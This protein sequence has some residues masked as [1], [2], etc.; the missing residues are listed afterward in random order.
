MQL[1]MAMGLRYE[2]GAG[3]S[4]LTDFSRGQQSA[5]ARPENGLPESVGPVIDV[6]AIE[7]PQ[8]QPVKAGMIRHFDYL[9][10]DLHADTVPLPLI[11]SR[12]D[13][14]I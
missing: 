10:Y 14:V 9:V 11:G 4:L 7:V 3:V 12:L 5:A 2:P 13:S 8:G 6:E 1:T